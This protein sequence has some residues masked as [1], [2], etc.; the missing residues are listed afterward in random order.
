MNSKDKSKEQVIEKEVE[1]KKN[2]N[3]NIKKNTINDN[4]LSDDFEIITQS[5][6]RYDFSFK[7][8]FLGDSGVGKTSITN[9]MIT[10]NF[11]KNQ[12]PTIGFDL[13]PFILKYKEKVI[14]LEIWDTCGQEVYRSLIK[15]FFINAS[16]AVVT[17]SVTD[18]N[19]FASIS[20]WLRECKHYCSP[21][22]RFLLVGN[23]SDYAK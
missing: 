22:T 10:G 11:S 14:K 19:S 3:S 2:E 16:L 1:N 7:I 23:K 8:I 18:R 9:R 4:N 15:S 12:S 21:K 13:F 17:Y 20:E 6:G 5:F